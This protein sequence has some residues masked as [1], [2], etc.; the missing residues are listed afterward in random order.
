M[1]V[2]ARRIYHIT[3]GTKKWNGFRV[4]A[5]IRDRDRVRV[6]VCAHAAGSASQGQ[7]AGKSD[8]L[9]ARS[10]TAAPKL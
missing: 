9:S 6:V 5:R 2:Q 8:H 1:V 7:R 10:R 4:R 3:F